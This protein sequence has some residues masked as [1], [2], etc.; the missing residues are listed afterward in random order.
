[1]LVPTQ[2]GEFDGLSSSQRKSIA[3]IPTTAE[4][5]KEMMSEEGSDSPMDSSFALHRNK[6][7]LQSNNR[8]FQMVDKLAPNEMLAKFA[9]RAPQVH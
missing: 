1:M 8:Y 4:D 9:K 7:E 6:A 5:L 3:R 2:S